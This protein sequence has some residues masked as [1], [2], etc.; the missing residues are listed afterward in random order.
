MCCASPVTLPAGQAK[1]NTLRQNCMGYRRGLAMNTLFISIWRDTQV[2]HAGTRTHTYSNSATLSYQWQGWEV[3]HPPRCSGLFLHC[4]QISRVSPVCYVLIHIHV[5]S[6]LC[7]KAPL[8][9]W[10]GGVVQ[11]DPE[12]RKT[13]L[14]HTSSIT[15]RLSMTH[16]VCD[17]M[18]QMCVSLGS[19]F[20]FKDNIYKKPTSCRPGPTYKVAIISFPRSSSA[21][22]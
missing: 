5:E 4:H 6:H 12:A 1:H 2:K 20:F 10:G 17:E 18:R 8:L 21:G 14:K 22:G 3:I 16:I 15:V 13:H 9:G 19:S 7:Q 11:E